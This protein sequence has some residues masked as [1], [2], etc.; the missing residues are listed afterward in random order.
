VAADQVAPAPLHRTLVLLHR[1]EQAHQLVARLVFGKSHPAL[2]QA[3][4]GL[5]HHAMALFAPL[6][7]KLRHIGPPLLVYPLGSSH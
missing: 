6:R 5:E 1:V 2:A 3:I 4:G 7:V